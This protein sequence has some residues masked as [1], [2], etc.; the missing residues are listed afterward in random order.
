MRS[1]AASVFMLLAVV[2]APTLAAAASCGLLSI[3]P[4]RTAE[5]I[6]TRISD[7]RSQPDS[8]KT[9]E[10]YTW[11]LVARSVANGQ[12]KEVWRDD[13]SGLLWSDSLDYTA[14][15]TSAGTLCA[16][17][18]SSGTLGV[19][20]VW[21]LPTYE[22]A[23]QAITRGLLDV[24]PHLRDSSSEMH[25]QFWI[26]PDGRARNEWYFD[27]ATGEVEPS[28]FTRMHSIRCVTLP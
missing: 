5:M 22:D 21:R 15:V 8:H 26:A 28:Y 24:L 2:P 10:G 27:G 23:K 1:F 25:D 3:S 6:L 4:A 17:N 13:G 18:A 7:C 12:A 16:S 14:T 20:G 19:E 9:V 11:T